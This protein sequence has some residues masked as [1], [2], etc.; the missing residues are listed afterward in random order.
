[1]DLEISIQQYLTK[2]YQKRSTIKLET[3][4]IINIIIVLSRQNYL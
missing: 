4:Y 2:S 1:M 3:K